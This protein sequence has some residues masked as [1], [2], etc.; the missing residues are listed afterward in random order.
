M[1]SALSSYF[2]PG[3]CP[4]SRELNQLFV[5]EQQCR[6]NV[7][8]SQDQLLLLQQLWHAFYPSQADAQRC[9]NES[10][11]HAEQA[12]SSEASQTY[13]ADF[14]LRSPLWKRMGFQREDPVSD[15]RGGG[16]LS[17]HCLLFFSTRYTELCQSMCDHQRCVRRTSGMEKGYPWAAAGIN[18]TR[19]V[20]ECFNLMGPMGSKGK[21]ATSARQCWDLLCQEADIV[22]SFAEL[23]CVA[24]QLVD[25]HFNAIGAGYMQFNQVLVHCKEKL[26]AAL[27]QRG[28]KSLQDL[29]CVLRLPDPDQDAHN[30]VEERIQSSRI[31]KHGNEQRAT[32]AVLLNQQAC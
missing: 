5:L 23:F 18:V 6:K 22:Q 14:S 9:L 29:R 12:T 20:A 28:L 17:L 4:D 10:F 25:Q 21:Y 7:I 8:P 32:D 24:F 15:V 26:M 13:S 16:E 31:H 1:F 2:S 27:A 3:R 11:A 30:K 19:M